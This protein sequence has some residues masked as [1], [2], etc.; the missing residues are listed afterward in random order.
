MVRCRSLH[1]LLLL[2]TLATASSC[3]PTNLPPIGSGA[4]AFQTEEDEK[5]LWQIAEQIERR[6]EKGGLLYQDRDLENYLDG[7]AGRLLAGRLEGTQVVPRVKIIKDPFLNAF[8][9]PDG[10]IY[11]HTGLLARMDN[12]AQLATVMGHEL[13]HFVERHSAKEMRSAQN[14]RNVVGVLQI[15]LLGGLGGEL[16]G[17]L[18]SVLALASVSGYSKE[19][20]TRAD[21]AGLRTLVQAGYDPKESVKAFELMKQNRDETKSKEPFFFGTHPRLEERI[22]NNARLLNTEFQAAAR[23]EG[24][25]K[26]SEEFLTR[27]H[28]LLLDN[29]ILDL[30]LGRFNTARAAIEKHLRREPGSP[31]GHFVMGELYRRSGRSDDAVKAYAYASFLDPKYAEPHRELGLLYRAQ[32]RPQDARAEFERYV[33]LSPKAID[34]LII[35]GYVA[36]LEKP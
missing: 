18:G 12:E 35:K 14:T 3:A 31:H 5:K 17:Q 21:E 1:T 9:L 29:A 25:V 11:F 10:A 28:R 19:L 26:N 2:F 27:T 33:D 16:A 20:E 6:I 7:V 22:D 13:T 24:R 23:E 30:E 15:L 8:T 32:S 36:E 34:A 4:R